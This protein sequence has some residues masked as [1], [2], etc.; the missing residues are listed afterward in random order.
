MELLAKLEDQENRR[1]AY[2]K[3]YNAS[4]SVA[5]KKKDAEYH[6]QY[7]QNRKSMLEMLRALNEEE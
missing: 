5:Q 6:R 2:H 3:K 7:N 1:K 4:K